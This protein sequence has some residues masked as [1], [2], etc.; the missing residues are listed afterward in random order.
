MQWCEELPESCPPK[1]AFAPSGDKIYY[2]IIGGP[3]PCEKDFFSERK[4][5]PDR[6]YPVSECQARSISIFPNKET[7]VLISKYP[8]FKNRPLYI[9]ELILNENDGV[10]ANT[11]SVKFSNHISWWKSVDFDMKKVTLSDE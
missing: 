7:C 9:A 11:P 4:L 10:I 2:R 3:I 1:C 5:H 8:K 6:P